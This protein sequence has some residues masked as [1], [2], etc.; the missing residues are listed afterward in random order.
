[1]T[2]K[3]LPFLKSDI[4]VKAAPPTLTELRHFHLTPNKRNQIKVGKLFFLATVTNYLLS[5]AEVKCRSIKEFFQT[6]QCND[7]SMALSCNKKKT[8]KK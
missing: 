8:K 5:A 1:M 4:M 7:K 2:N 6:G 3:V